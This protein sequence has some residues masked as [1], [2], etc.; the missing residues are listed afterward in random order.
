MSVIWAQRS[1]DSIPVGFC[2]W[3]SHATQ[4]PHVDPE[5]S[6]EASLEDTAAK[7]PLHRHFSPHWHSNV[8][9]L[10]MSAARTSKS[11][12]R[13]E[14]PRLMSESVLQ[15]LVSLLSISSL[16]RLMLLMEWAVFVDG[17]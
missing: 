14:A 7:Q 15:Q 6:F 5:F 1:T 8:N 9:D 12:E 13:S 16:H 10:D 4:D 17:V 3:I 2:N 11:I